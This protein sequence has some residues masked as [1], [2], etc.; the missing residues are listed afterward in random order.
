MSRIRW[1]IRRGV[2]PDNWLGRI[3]S[4]KPRM[5]APVAL[6]NKMAGIIWGMMTREQN[7]RM[8]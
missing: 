5:V 7:Y 4:R 2:F 1:I 6:V 8:A 3:L